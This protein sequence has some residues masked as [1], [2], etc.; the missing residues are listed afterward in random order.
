MQTRQTKRIHLYDIVYNLLNVTLLYQQ[1]PLEIYA[2]Q[3]ISISWGVWP[4][5]G[6]WNSVKRRS[7]SG[8]RSLRF[9]LPV[10]TADEKSQNRNET[11]GPEDFTYL[12]VIYCANGS[13]FYLYILH[14][15]CH[16]STQFIP[17][18]QQFTHYFI[19]HKLYIICDYFSK[20]SGRAFMFLGKDFEHYF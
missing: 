4:S 6:N 9:Q 12:C 5:P 13:M 19:I 17:G 2:K 16:S 1:T 8:N 15:S 14:S 10:D 7:A 18:P 3:M 20:W 11:K